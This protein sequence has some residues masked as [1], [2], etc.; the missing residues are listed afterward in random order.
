ME[1]L[2]FLVTAIFFSFLGYGLC[3]MTLSANRKP[4][5]QNANPEKPLQKLER[6]V[7]H[8]HTA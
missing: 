6:P 7:Q 4:K 3:Y 1:G 2:N 5:T 8:R